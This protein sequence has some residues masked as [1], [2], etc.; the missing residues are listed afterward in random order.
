M[1]RKATIVEVDQKNFEQLKPQ[2]LA[3]IK[4]A[5]FVAFDCEFTG[6]HREKQQGVNV[7]LPAKNRY[8][9]L[10]QTMFGGAFLSGKCPACGMDQM[11][12]SNF[13]H[14][15]GVKRHHSEHAQHA[16]AGVRR[17]EFLIA[18]VGFSCFI[19]CEE[20]KDYDIR[21]F[22]CYLSPRPWTPGGPNASSNVKVEHDLKFSCMG[23]SLKFLGDHDFD[24]NRWINDGI[25]FMSRQQYQMERE[26]LQ[27]RTGHRSTS[28]A[29]LKDLDSGRGFLEVWDALLSAGKPLV[30]HQCFLDILYL[31]HQLEGPLHKDLG[32]V[33]RDFN[34]KVKV[35]VDTKHLLSW[36]PRDLVNLFDRE[37]AH[38]RQKK[39]DKLRAELAEKER[40][41][42]V[43]K[44]K[45]QT[46]SPTPM[47]PTPELPDTCGDDQSPPS[48]VLSPTTGEKDVRAELLKKKAEMIEAIKHNVCKELLRALT[49]NEDQGNPYSKMHLHELHRLLYP[50]IQDA[51]PAF[52]QAKEHDAG[53]DAYMTGAVFLGLFS[54]M[55]PDSTAP[56]ASVLLQHHGRRSKT[57]APPVSGTPQ[58]FP[59]LNKLYI[60]AAPYALD[61]AG[62]LP[63]IDES[64]SNCYTVD[65]NRNDPSGL[66]DAQQLQADLR[67]VDQFAELYWVD[68]RKRAVIVMFRR[69]LTPDELYKKLKEQLGP[70]YVS[71]T[72]PP[73]PVARAAVAGKSP[74][75]NA[76]ALSASQSKLASVK[77]LSKLKEQLLTTTKRKQAAAAAAAAQKTPKSP[78][79]R[80]RAGG[81]A[82]AA[83]A[84]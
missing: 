39:L 5:T 82:A 67:K 25:P 14:H 60:F 24:F 16:H 32:E 27:Q 40:L 58:S 61:T 76:A 66:I 84:A 56:T 11:E 28:Y 38:S 7:L 42:K 50:T 21:C 31:W 44:E 20:R 72:V 63:T 37:T 46:K 2:M 71:P 12:D 19:W 77:A 9:L 70:L 54:L 49:D 55:H 8:A 43:T 45:E 79:A 17:Q 3:A 6:L 23:S 52:S 1:S 15:C 41:R 53:Y 75:A 26:K 81:S 33:F 73:K 29:T 36:Y 62:V 47:S 22:S 51:I 83:A 68:F 65:P 78:P 80:P 35:M 57:A 64:H 74:T 34:S 30:G 18:Q 13:C 10:R 48:A 59:F 4:A 69:D